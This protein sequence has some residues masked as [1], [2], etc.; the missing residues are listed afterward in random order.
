[1][2]PVTF[3]FLSRRPAQKFL[4]MPHQL[5]ALLAWRNSTQNCKC[6]QELRDLHLQTSLLFKVSFFQ[7]SVLSKSEV[8]WVMAW[9][10][11]LRWIF[12]KCC[13]ER[14]TLNVLNA[15]CAYKWEVFFNLRTQIIR[16][17]FPCFLC[18]CFFFFFFFLNPFSKWNLEDVFHKNCHN[19]LCSIVTIMYN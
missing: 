7:H 10:A 12:W 6:G 19:H 3:P 5:L 15:L 17:G 2:K 13:L 18:W 11:L 9:R 4:A 1:M 16:Q 14:T 8:P